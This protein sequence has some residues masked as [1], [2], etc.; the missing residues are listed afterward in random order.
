M[1]W[2]VLS[3]GKAVDDEIDALPADMRAKLARFRR[4]IE[5]HGPMALPMPYARFLGD[6]L[7]ELRLS[8]RDGIARV[9]YITMKERRVV[10]LRAFVKKTQ[11]TP[12]H[13]L[14]IARQRMRTLQT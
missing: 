12:A 6:G 7:W 2:V 9:I 3:W 8:G 14:A 10:L 4:E 11:K 5:M 1:A 13:E